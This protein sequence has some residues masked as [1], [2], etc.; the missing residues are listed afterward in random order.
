MCARAHVYVC[1]CVREKGVASTKW[2]GRERGGREYGRHV[3]SIV[4]GVL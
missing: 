2:E 3:C 4:C 1:V